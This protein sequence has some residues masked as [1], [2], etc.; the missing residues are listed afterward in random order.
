[1]HAANPEK[2]KVVK[3][4]S[5]GDI[6]FAVARKPGTSRL[7]CG[8]SDFTVYEIDVDQAKPEAKELGRHDSYVTSLALAGTTLVSGGYDGRLIWWNIE[9]RSKIR[10]VDAHRKWIRGVAATPDGTVVASVADDMV[11][12]S[13]TSR[14]AG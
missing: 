8:G 4:L 7:F 6:V 3:Q 1:M 10:E 5:R 12:R 11:C 9:S 13:G 2:L 14:A